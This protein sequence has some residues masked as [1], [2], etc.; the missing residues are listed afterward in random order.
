MREGRTS[1][2]VFGG[3]YPTAD[4]TCVRDYVHVCDLARAHL[5]ALERLHAGAESAVYNLGNGGGFS[6][7]EVVRACAEATDRDVD[8]VIG[9]RR[10]GDPAVLVASADKA[11]GALGWHPEYTDLKVMV[12]DAW[13]WHLAHPNG[14]R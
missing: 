12:A 4:G 7:L 14:Y 2:E 9:P 1:F 6:N 13:R 10:P 11:A 8:V 3:D 5:L